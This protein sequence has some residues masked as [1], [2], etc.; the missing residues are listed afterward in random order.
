MNTDIDIGLAALT[1]NAGREQTLSSKDIAEVCNCTRSYIY[2]LEK[3]ALAKL[4]KNKILL[5]WYC[6]QD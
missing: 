6:E 2:E 1:D 4:R 3:K 5:A